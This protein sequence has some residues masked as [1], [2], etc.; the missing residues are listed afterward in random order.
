MFK[1]ESSQKRVVFIFHFS[2][3][4]RL[5]VDW[6]NHESGLGVDVEEGAALAWGALTVASK[7]GRWQN[8]HDVIL[9]QQN[10]KKSHQVTPTGSVSMRTVIF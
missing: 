2:A 7:M 5:V 3:G 10:A 4:H 9:R 1:L 8:E 6:Q